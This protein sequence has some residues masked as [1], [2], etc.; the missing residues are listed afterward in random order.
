MDGFEIDDT[1][2][3]FVSHHINAWEES[4][5]VVVD[6][7]TQPF[8]HRDYFLFLDRFLHHT[9]TNAG[10]AKTLVKRIRIDLVT[11]NVH[12]TD[13]PNKMNNPI[14]NTFDYPTINPN[15][16]GIKNQFVFGL[17]SIDYWKQTLIKK[18]LEDS[19]KDK[20]WSEASTYPGEMV[21]IP[22]PGKKYVN[23]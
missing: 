13:W 15:K 17:A 10:S 2:V 1:S 23:I 21:F 22:N 3:Q 14:L 4:Q 8:D 5:D 18:N 12:V 16:L 20:T 7:V 9:E 19:G 11:E 6:V